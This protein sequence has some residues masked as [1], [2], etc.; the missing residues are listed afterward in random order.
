[1]DGNRNHHSVISQT[2]KHKYHVFSFMRNLKIHTYID[3][4]ETKRSKEAEIKI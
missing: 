4:E 1:M 3:V 2:Q